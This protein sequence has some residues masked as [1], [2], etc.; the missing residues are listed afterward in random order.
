MLRLQE[1]VYR[2]APAAITGHHGQNGL[3]N[4]KDLA[5]SG[6]W[7]P[8]NTVLG[9]WVPNENPLPG[10]KSANEF[11]GIFLIKTLI[12]SHQNSILLDSFNPLTPIKTMSANTVT[13]C[14]GLQHMNFMCVNGGIVNIHSI[15]DAILKSFLKGHLVVKALQATGTELN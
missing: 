9:N 6:I 14:A 10:G 2:S 8:K 15:I 7:K 1:A 12:L 3:T 5:I 11:S 13:L 4:R